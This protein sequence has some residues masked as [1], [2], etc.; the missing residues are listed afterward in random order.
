MSTA[1]S[2]GL[3]SS[4]QSPGDPP[5]DSTSFTLTTAGGGV[6]PVEQVTIAVAVS[7]QSPSVTF[8]VIVTGP[9][10]VQ[11]KVGL[12]TSSALSVPVLALKW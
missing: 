10:T 2:P 1:P 8:S 9:A 6:V 12:A 5:L 3:K 11:V 7:P 4:I